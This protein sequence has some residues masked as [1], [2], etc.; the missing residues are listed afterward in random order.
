MA[1]QGKREERMK[2]VRF[3]P[4][5]GERPGVWLET[6][7][8]AGAEILD[9]RAMAF[10][11][12]DYDG[13]F[14][15]GHGLARLER[16]IAERNRKTVPAGSVRLGPPLARPG[17]IMCLGK[18]Y[19]DHAKEF[20]SAI[21][22]SPIVFSKAASAI[23]GPFDPVELA[24]SA[25]G[26]DW[27]VE[28]AVVIGSECR[29]VSEAG[30]MAHVAGYMILNDV[31]DRDAQKAAGQWFRGKSADTFCPMG[32]FMVT[33]GDVPDPHRLRLRSWRNGELFQD[34]NSAQMLFKIPALIAFLSAA[35]TLEPGDVIATGT[36]AGI[37]AARR[38]S[39]A[40][41]IVCKKCGFQNPED[42]MFCQGCG[43]AVTAQGACLGGENLPHFSPFSPARW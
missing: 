39:G 9:V 15:A 11:I 3:G 4:R 23:N 22:E 13:R 21:P 8:K 16:L 34:G 38:I 42:A 1:G 7:D 32:P 24:P 31:T 40:K 2:L 28:L 17:K 36:P 14:F 29:R 6:G 12:E 27:E 41:M 37:G 20:D 18:N 43:G 25:G 30:A 10:D 19:A 33:A 5:G 35:I 26:V